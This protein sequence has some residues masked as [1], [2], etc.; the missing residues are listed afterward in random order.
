MPR[1]HVAQEGEWIE[2]RRRGF[3]WGCCDC[4]LVHE[5]DF[6]VRADGTLR[7]RVRRDGRATANA[8]R[9]LRRGVD[10]SGGG[11]VG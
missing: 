10:G 11:A 9:P 3:R 1:Y 5:V 6:E 2:P 8:R 7:F 4:G